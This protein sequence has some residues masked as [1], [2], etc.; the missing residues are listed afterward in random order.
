[1]TF[2]KPRPKMVTPMAITARLG[3]AR[4]TFEVLI[5]RKAP[6][7][8]CPS[9]RPS[10]TAITVAIASDAPNSLRVQMTSLWSVSDQ[11]SWRK[12]KTLAMTTVRS[13]SPD[14]GRRDP[15]DH[16]E[17]RVGRDAEQD[18]QHA[19]GDELGLE[20]AAVERLDD[21]DAEAGVV[22]RSRDGGQADNR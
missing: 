5:A 15:L 19:A 2:V 21:R 12:V 16:R 22:N 7:W 13:S 10:G 14:P 6:R 1:M 3:S 18:G 20:R 4:P 11:W 8:M 17:H 9:Q